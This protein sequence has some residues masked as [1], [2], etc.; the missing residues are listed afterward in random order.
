[1]RKGYKKEVWKKLHNPAV[2]PVDTMVTGHLPEM[3][4]SWVLE[5]I[6]NGVVANGA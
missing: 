3:A 2:S 6:N 1:M 5:V 4:S